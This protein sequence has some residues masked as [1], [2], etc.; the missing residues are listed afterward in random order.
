MLAPNRFAPTFPPLTD[1]YDV[2]NGMP[3]VNDTTMQGA[4]VTVNWQA[5]DA[6]SLKSVTAYRESDT[7]T[8]IDFDTLP[9]ILADVRAE[10]TDDQLT[11][12]FQA[13]YTRREPQRRGGALLL[14]R[15][16]RRHCAQQLLQPA[17]R[18][19][20][21]TRQ[22]RS[23]SAPPTASSTPRV[24]L[25]GEGTY[26]VSERFKVTAGARYTYEEKS[27]DALNQAYANATF[28]T[29]IA[30]LADFNDSVS[31]NNS[32]RSLARLPGHRPDHGLRPG[33]RG[34]KSG[35][36]NIRANTVAASSRPFADES[37]TSSRSARSRLPRRHL[38]PQPRLF[39]EQVQ[40]RAAVGVHLLV[41]QRPAVFFGDFTN[42][43]RHVK[44]PELE[45][46]ATDRA[47]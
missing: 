6:W 3:N 13:T 40:G 24:R 36:Y 7:E 44:G 21:P 41:L 38:L 46:V 23:R 28:S 19:S 4:S 43:G 11:Q 12:E 25:Y 34:F 31:S 1:R 30:T 22:A 14:R 47:G 27:V 2:R 16:R 42:A 26:Q 8:N 17:S 45:L 5:S 39:L 35:G 9:N 37:V 10:Y 29:P 33:R 20:F 15:H 32:R 18:R